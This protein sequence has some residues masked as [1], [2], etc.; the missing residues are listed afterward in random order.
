VKG[1]D[2]LKEVLAVTNGSECLTTAGE[3]LRRNLA[4]IEEMVET[5]SK[6]F[7][8]D[9]ATQAKRVKDQLQKLEELYFHETWDTAEVITSSLDWSFAELDYETGEFSDRVHQLD[10]S[11]S[12]L[13]QIYEQF[14]LPQAVVMLVSSLEVYLSTVFSCCLFDMLCLN[15]RAVSKISSRYNFQNWGDSV[16][17][18][19]TFLG[20]ELCPEGV[21]SSEV[22]GL[23]QRR[24]VLVHRTGMID[25]RAVHQLSLPLSSI[26][27]RLRIKYSDVME[28][29][30]LVRR[31]GDHLHLSIGKRE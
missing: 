20:I 23:Q 1:F 25:E 9:V 31:I 3:S 22:V 26:G 14:V 28:N 16:D 29:I 8:L 30:E 6:V 21:N 17:A 18:F 27:E 4:S 12:R 2:E 10:E 7:E 15:D 13:N 5:F 19:R 11:L 24:H